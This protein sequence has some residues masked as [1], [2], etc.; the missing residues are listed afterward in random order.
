LP[1]LNNLVTWGI[2]INYFGKA[3]RRSLL[4]SGAAGVD[5]RSDASGG[6]A[7][8]GSTGILRILAAEREPLRAQT[9]AGHTVRHVLL[10]GVE[11]THFR[12]G[13]T[14]FSL[15]FPSF[16]SELSRTCSDNRGHHHRFLAES[17]NDL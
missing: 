13:A 14:L 1:A 5:R 7:S 9:E 4:G 11:E 2:S 10:Q 8:S 15:R 3:M 6:A 16:S 17:S 12:R